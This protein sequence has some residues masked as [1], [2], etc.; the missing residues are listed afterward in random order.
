MT[1]AAKRQNDLEAMCGVPTRYLVRCEA[2][3]HQGVVVYTMQG[4]RQ[5]HFYCSQCGDSEPDVVLM[6]GG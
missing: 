2:C 1:Q 5:P 4:R 6:R 3:G